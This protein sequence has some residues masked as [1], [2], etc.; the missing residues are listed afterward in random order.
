MQGHPAARATLQGMVPP[1]AIHA[2]PSWG[3][4]GAGGE[5]SLLPLASPSG[6]S[7]REQLA[8]ELAHAGCEGSSH[9]QGQQHA[10]AAA[11]AAAQ[12]HV[13]QYAQPYVSQ[14]FQQQAY[15][16]ARGLK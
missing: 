12:H 2:M 7:E 11:A 8:H 14:A 15:P 5:A 4:A 9:Y 3:K 13:Q 10:A 1:L 6:R 16:K